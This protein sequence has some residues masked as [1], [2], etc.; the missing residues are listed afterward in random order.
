MT[1]GGL[2]LG[3]SIP[4]AAAHPAVSQTQSERRGPKSLK[5]LRPKTFVLNGKAHRFGEYRLSGERF[6]CFGSRAST[7]VFAE[8]LANA[9]LFR[10]TKSDRRMVRKLALVAEEGFEPP[11]QGL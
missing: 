10:P 9:G 8:S 11:T 4:V 2:G 5:S 7:Q 6:A 1:H 3:C